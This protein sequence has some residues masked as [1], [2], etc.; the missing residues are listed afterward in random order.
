[1]AK[2]TEQLLRC[3]FSGVE[4]EIEPNTSGNEALVGAVSAMSSLLLTGGGIG[5]YM[6]LKSRCCPIVH[7]DG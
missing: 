3:N 2:N 7:V 6:L 4:V 1:M 5:L